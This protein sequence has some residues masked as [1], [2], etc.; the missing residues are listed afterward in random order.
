MPKSKKGHQVI[1]FHCRSG[2]LSWSSEDK[3]SLENK[4]CA[5]NLTVLLEMPTKGLMAFGLGLQHVGGKLGFRITHRQPREIHEPWCDWWRWRPLASPV[6]GGNLTLQHPGLGPWGN[7]SSPASVTLGL[8]RWTVVVARAG[9]PWRCTGFSDLTSGFQ[10][11]GD[12]AQ[13]GFWLLHSDG[14]L[15]RG[16]EEEQSLHFMILC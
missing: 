8:S 7:P 14:I 10:E 1:E 4:L 3:P 13:T 6:S 16:K 5:I 12:V 11:R 2:P 9:G 15:G